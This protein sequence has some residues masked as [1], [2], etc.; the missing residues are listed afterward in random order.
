MQQG[1]A[2][3]AVRLVHIV[4]RVRHELSSCATSPWQIKRQIQRFAAAQASIR[5][6]NSLFLRCQLGNDETG[7]KLLCP[8]P[9]IEQVICRMNGA[10]YSVMLHLPGPRCRHAGIEEA[11]LITI[12]RSC[13]VLPAPM[14]IN[15][16]RSS[17]LMSLG[18]TCKTAHVYVSTTLVHPK[19]SA[20]AVSFSADLMKRD[21][22]LLIH[23]RLRASFLCLCSVH[24]S[25]ALEGGGK[26]AW[27]DIT[28]RWCTSMCPRP[29]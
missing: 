11:L 22:F 28:R 1:P 9:K 24:E 26:E 14:M 12:L 10:A 19:E 2:V 7:S 20:K 25:C 17:Q 15:G 3:A 16:S 21:V 27:M 29:S 4:S 13:R 6:Q 18:K 23:L 5:F 8:R